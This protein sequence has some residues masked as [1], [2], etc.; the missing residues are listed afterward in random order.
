M[1][2]TISNIMTRA[3]ARYNAENDTFYSDAMLIAL[4]F[5]A[6][7]Q[8]AKKGWVIENTLTT[9]T[10]IDQREYPYPENTLAIKE[11]RYDSDKLFPSSL[12]EDPKNSS[13]DPTGRP[14]H[15]AIWDNNILLFPTPNNT[16]TMQARVYS[17]PQPITASTDAIEVPQEYREDLINY[18]VAIMAFKD[19]NFAMYDRLI[20]IWNNVVL[21]EAERQRRRRKRGD[22]QARTKDFYFGS[23]IVPKEYL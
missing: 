22:R 16:L 10:V 19:Q 1:T 8:L 7:S 21:P 17:Y 5:D 2:T 20:G 11:V 12:S 15:Y 13:G 9:T 23:D 4:I 6:Q 14:T 18:V 3:R